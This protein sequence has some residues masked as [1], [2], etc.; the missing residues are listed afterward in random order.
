[1]HFEK[2][3][4]PTGIVKLIS[5]SV[6]ETNL[7]SDK[8]R[9]TFDGHDEVSNFI[10]NINGTEYN[11]KQHP[12][13]FT[14]QGSKVMFRANIS[15][16][17]SVNIYAYLRNEYGTSEKSSVY[18]F[19]KKSSYDNV[20][21]GHV[22][23]AAVIK[24]IQNQIKDK[25]KAYGINY[26]FTDIIPKKT[27]VSASIYNECYDALKAINNE[28]NSIINT[29]TFDVTMISNRISSISLHDDML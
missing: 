15:N 12:S 2:G 10:V 5:P 21:E 8:C 3:S 24:E 28:L 17:T 27:Y 18:R 23:T 7:Y 29:S 11:I 13:L 22:A 6:D 9:F 14:I 4:K 16:M 20:V 1:M 19:N 26:S 25:A